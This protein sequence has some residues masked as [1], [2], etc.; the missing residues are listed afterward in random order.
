[1]SP[2]ADARAEVCLADEGTVRHV[3]GSGTLEAFLTPGG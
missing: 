1:L 3:Y 2:A